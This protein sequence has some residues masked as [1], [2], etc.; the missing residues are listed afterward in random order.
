[1]DTSAL[2]RHVS[3]IRKM[4]R[5]LVLS[6]MG[7]DGLYCRIVSSVKILGKSV[8]SNTISKISANFC[9]VLDQ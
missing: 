5:N 7:T 6:Y 2:I 4:P 1:M 8:I 3:S 9:E